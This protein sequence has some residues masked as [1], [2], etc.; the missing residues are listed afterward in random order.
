MGVVG[1]ALMIGGGIMVVSRWQAFEDFVREATL[2]V[3]ERDQREHAA[4]AKRDA[5]REVSVTLDPT[6]REEA[7]GQGHCCVS[8]GELGER[9]R[10]EVERVLFRRWPRMR[11][12][13]DEQIGEGDQVAFVV[14]AGSDPLAST[15]EL[16]V[17]VVVAVDGDRLIVSPSCTP[18]EQERHGIACKTLTLVPRGTVIGWVREGDVERGA[19]LEP[20]MTREVVR[21]VR[22]GQPVQLAAT[23]A[24][25]R[26]WVVEPSGA[27]TVVELGENKAGRAEQT[28]TIAL[29]R[30]RPGAVVCEL[31]GDTHLCQ[32]ARLGRWRMVVV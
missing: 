3:D 31:Y 2:S 23:P 18:Q 14:E 7:R 21:Y 26:E 27:A 22:P 16:L 1:A 6:E 25:G 8:R 24:Q 29:Q 13:G 15:R 30:A 12:L 10:A 28:L 11:Q 5:E 32:G 20:W 19:K 9:Q 17:G 4:A